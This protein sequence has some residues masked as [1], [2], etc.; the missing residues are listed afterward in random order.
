[1][2]C[3][4]TAVQANGEMGKEVIVFISGSILHFH[5][6]PS[7]KFCKTENKTTKPKFSTWQI[8]C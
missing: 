1:M 3:L 5:L 8:C 2:I 7:N 6:Q 4:K